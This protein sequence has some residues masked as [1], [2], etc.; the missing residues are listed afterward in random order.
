MAT[1]IKKDLMKL[2]ETSYSYIF[3]QDV[4]I[5]LSGGVLIR[6]NIYYP[7]G[8]KQGEKYP[9]LVTYGPYG[10]DVP[11][12]AFRP[13]SFAELNPDHKSNHAAWETPFPAYWTEHGYIVIRADEVGIGQS[14]GVLDVWSKVVLDTFCELIEWAAEQKW[15]TGKIGLTGI[16]YYGAIQWQAAARHT[17]GLAAIIPWEGFADL[18]RDATR[19]G[20]ILSNGFLRYWYDLQVVPNQYGYPGRE[21]TGWGPN[22]SEGNLT[23]EE[24]ES[25]RVDISD[26]SWTY[27]FAE[28]DR[29]TAWDVKLEDIRVPLLSVANWG[30]TMLHLRGNVE[31]FVRAGSTFKYLRFITGR[32]DLPFYYPEEVELQR[33]FLDAFLKNEDRDGWSK[34]GAIP[35]VDLVLRKGDVGYND[36]NAELT[37][38]R[39]K[40]TEWPI[41]RT[42][43]R[44]LFL[45]PAKE[46]LF[47]KPSADGEKLG[48]KALG[49]LE[50]PQLIS[51]TSLPFE[52]ETEVTGHMVAHLHVSVAADSSGP[53]PSD[54]DLFL[55]VRHL[56]KSGK[57]ISYTGTLGGPNC[58]TK[59]WLRVSLRKTNPEHPLH[60]HYLPRREY[61]SVDQLPVV[62][63]EI[64]AVDVELWPTNVVLEKGERLV[65]EISSGDTPGVEIS[66][67]NYPPD[68]SAEKFQGTNFIHFGQ[69]HVNY[70][71]VPIIPPQ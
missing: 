24:L 11:Y 48:Y 68:R 38:P 18:Y 31:G 29:F 10:K 42:Q 26:R 59:G 34:K 1:P 23:A 54:I 55:S 60:R 5:P 37:Y 49:T 53:V 27:P 30:G 47:S 50:S 22:T 58:V 57:E 28:G 62:P 8:V 63:N 52:S 12:E 21:A 67:H 7:K 16:S 66:V 25:S 6:S 2:D 13:T 19:H 39:R 17:K 51:F 44:D 33:S 40:E 15:S 45:T 32:H 64:Y 56:S 20:G 14:P 70:L 46:L 35:A 69:H 9:V 65:F 3:E 43:Y 41:A 71:R 36:P 4:S 61:R